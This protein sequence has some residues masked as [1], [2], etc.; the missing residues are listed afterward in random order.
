MGRARANN[1]RFLKIAKLRTL[2]QLSKF[3][4]NLISQKMT[5]SVF[6]KREKLPRFQ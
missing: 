4:E 5:D 6:E 3:A 1:G 2:K